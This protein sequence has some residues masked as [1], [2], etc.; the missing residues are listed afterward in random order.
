G[1]HIVALNSV[2]SAVE[3]L[4]KKNSIY[5][6]RQVAPSMSGEPELMGYSQ[7]MAYLQYGE[8]FRSFRKNCHRIFGS[9]TAL[10]AYHPID[11]METCRFLKRVLTKLDRL[12]AY[13]RRTAGAVILCICYGYEVKEHGDPLV[14]MA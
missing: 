10:V 11:E 6:N 8:R 4:D 7:T 12:Q 3:M 9:R 2:K 1:M 13:V 5:S 14:D